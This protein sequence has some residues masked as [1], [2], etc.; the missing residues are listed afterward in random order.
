MTAKDDAI[1]KGVDL[2]Q[3]CFFKGLAVDTTNSL[4]PDV[5]QKLAPEVVLFMESKAKENT[6]M[7]DEKKEQELKFQEYEGKI[8]T[9]T[10]ALEEKSLAF[11]NLEKAVSE[12]DTRIKSLEEQVLAFMKKAEDDDWEATKKKVPVGFCHKDKETEN[13]KMWKETPHKFYDAVLAFKETQKE[14]TAPEGEEAPGAGVPEPQGLGT[15]DPFTRSFK[16]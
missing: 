1:L 8:A 11:Q 5:K 14:G 10:K 9:V 6:I 7:A 3:V 15:W 2:A 12:K 4:W 16:N 13:R